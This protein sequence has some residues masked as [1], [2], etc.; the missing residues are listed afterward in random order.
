VTTCTG[1]SAERYSVQT[2]GVHDGL[3]KPGSPVYRRWHEQVMQLPRRRA[4]AARRH[5]AHLLPER[6]G[7][8]VP[9]RAGG[10]HAVAARAAAHAPTWWSST[11]R[12]RS[13]PFEREFVEAEQ[14]AYMET[15]VEDDEIAL[16][17]DAGRRAL[18]NRGDDDAGPYQS[19]MEDGMQHFH[20]WYRREMR[21]PP[22]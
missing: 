21:D 19:P 5:L 17:M 7:G 6:D 10:V 11:T 22:A 3:R 15:C 14:A 12:R 18:M 13:S 2:V 8:V 1:S 20:E 4:A 16:R 9:A